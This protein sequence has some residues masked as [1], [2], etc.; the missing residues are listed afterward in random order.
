M[1]PCDICGGVCNGDLIATC[2]QCS[3]AREHVYCMRNHILKVPDVWFCESCRLKLDIASLKY[4]AKEPFPKTLTSNCGIIHSDTH[5]VGP[6]KLPDGTGRQ[7]NKR[8]KMIETAKVKFIS[9]Q[10]AIKLSSG[11]KKVES[12]V[13]SNLVKSPCRWDNMASVSKR[14]PVGS[15]TVTPKLSQLKVTKNPRFGPPGI[16]KPPSHFSVK[17]VPQAAKEFKATKTLVVHSKEHICREQP[18]QSLKPA[19]E[20]ETSN[21]K[22]EKV[23]NK[24]ACASSSSMH[25]LP[26]D[27]SG[28]NFFD[29]AE[30]GNS[31]V[32]E[33]NLLNILSTLKKHIP[34]PP[35]T[36]S[37]WEG[38]FEILG[39]TTHGKHYDGFKAHPPSKVHR[40]AYDFSKQ[41]CTNLQFKLLPRCNLWADIFQD[42]CPDENDIGLYIV[43]RDSN[44]ERSKQNYICL[45]KVLETNDFV[46][47]SYMN[48][49]ELLVFTSKQLRLHVSSQRSNKTYFLWGVF[50]HVKVDEAVTKEHKG[51]PLLG[52]PSECAPSDYAN[53]D[54]GELS[55]MEIDM[56]GGTNVGTV[57]VPVPKESIRRV[58]G[59]SWAESAQGT[60]LQKPDLLEVKKEPCNDRNPLPKIIQKVKSEF[61]NGTDNLDSPP[62]FK[63]RYNPGRLPKVE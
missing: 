17:Q 46:M 10:E 29:D 15:K 58:C 30:L 54:N 28:G 37:T 61:S 21:A 32:E 57:D 2:S 4:G 16:L 59:S 8:Q 9:A 63:V 34:N 23:T 27:S 62:G 40:K 51:L 43:P 50:R 25:C 41:M 39:S 60:L 7:D 3:V 6:K 24:A 42:D 52:S 31:I 18:I 44:F 14:T 56:I 12:P 48:G 19:S 53:E 1:K 22:V 26:F 38:S 5:L 45:L 20:C 11:T 49:V 47:R 33:N 35:R 13:R 55:D 36:D